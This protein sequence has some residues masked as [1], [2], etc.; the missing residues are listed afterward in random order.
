MVYYPTGLAAPALTEWIETLAPKEPMREGIRAKV[1]V[2]REQ[3][4]RALLAALKEYERLCLQLLRLVPPA[5]EVQAWSGLVV[6]CSRE[7]VGAQLRC[8]VEWSRR[9]RQR[10]GEYLARRSV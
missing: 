4:S 9:T 5:T 10:I 2:A 1:A 6:D 3:D 8:E 7:A